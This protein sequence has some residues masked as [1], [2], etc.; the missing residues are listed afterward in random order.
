MI[1][2]LLGFF[3]SESLGQ[4]TSKQYP[5]FIDAATFGFYPDAEGHLLTPESSELI[6]LFIKDLLKNKNI[7]ELY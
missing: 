4:S 1:L 7:Q 2:I 6:H 5:G 3:G